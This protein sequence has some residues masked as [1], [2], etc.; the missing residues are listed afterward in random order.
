MSISC[1][2][3]YKS[4]ELCFNTDCVAKACQRYSIINNYHQK[5]KKFLYNYK[6]RADTLL[7]QT[8]LSD[9]RSQSKMLFDSAACKCLGFS[10]CSCVSAKKVP[11]KEREFLLDQRTNKKM[12]ISGVDLHE[13]LRLRK[14]NDLR[15]RRKQLQPRNQHH[16]PS[17]EL[18]V[19][20][21][22]YDSDASKSSSE[23][24]DNTDD[25]E[26]FKLPSKGGS[27]TNLSSV[28]QVCDRAGVSD[29]TAALLASSLLLDMR[30][31]NKNDQS[32]VIDHLK[33]RRERAK[34]QKDLQ[35]SVEAELDCTFAVFFDGR[36]DKTLKKVNKG[37]KSSKNL[38]SEEHICMLREPGSSYVGHVS[39]KTESSKHISEEIL[40]LLTSD[41][42]SSYLRAI[43]CDGTMVNTGT[44][45]GVIVGLERA[46][47]SLLQ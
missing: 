47:I 38:V 18:D 43:G 32:S 39:P 12:I 35:H 2:L 40:E 27:R 1:H 9:F 19:L 11:R 4:L 33:I 5:F 25:E 45:N 15:N 3:G 36:I 7:S 29:R 46:L 21:L 16:K 41:S 24:T 42:Y 30:Q 44:T 37:Y 26:V 14:L 13:S 34:V 31:I 20:P 6:A 17:T 28:A 10:A 22:D 8:K 23:E